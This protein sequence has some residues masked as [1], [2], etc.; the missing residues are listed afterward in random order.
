M[1]G[2]LRYTRKITG[3]SNEIIIGNIHIYPSNIIGVNNLTCQTL[4]TTSL[5]SQFNTITVNGGI[6]LGGDIIMNGNNITGAG[7]IS[8]TTFTGTLSTN[9]QPNITSL[10]TLNTLTVNNSIT[11]NNMTNPLRVTNGTFTTSMTYSTPTANRIITFPDANITVN[12][13]NNI[14]GTTLSNNVVNSNLTSVGTLTDL[15]VSGKIN[16]DS[17]AKC[18]V[19][20]NSETQ[21]IVSYGVRSV[22]ITSGYYR[23]FVFTFSEPF[24]DTSYAWSGTGTYITPNVTDHQVVL[25]GTNGTIFKTTS[26]IK[27]SVLPVNSSSLTIYPTDISFIAFSL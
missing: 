26:Y 25:V 6:Q 18:W 23:N 27:L 11:V 19:N 21:D 1:S 7:T 20:F 4:T 15:T 14:S 10:G 17:V 13:A 12:A 24:E 9:S 16:N 22:L 5:S 3:G 8:A 2:R